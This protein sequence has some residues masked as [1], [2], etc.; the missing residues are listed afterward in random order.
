MAYRFKAYT[1]DKRIVQGTIDAASEG[2][3][4][5]T[6]YQAGYQRVLNLKEIR[7]GLSLGQSIPTLFGIKVQDVID[8]SRQLATLIESG[9]TILTAMQLLEEQAFRAA[10]RKVIAGLIANLRGGSSFSQALSKY[11]QAFSYTYCQVV[12]ASELTGNLEVG[13]RQ[14]AGYM[15]KQA[16][17]R[18]KIT[19]SLAY[20]MM[21]LFMA[22]GVFVLLITVALPPLVGLFTSLGAE[23][24]WTTRLLITAASFLIAHSLLASSR[25][26]V[27]AARRSSDRRIRRHAG[28]L[29]FS[30]K[31]LADVKQVAE[32][33]KHP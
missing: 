16:A 31:V 23:L 7:P 8:F 33:K 21:V 26:P 32:G 2:I 29:G 30:R 24:P 19:R 5:E 6:L 3:A 14:M 28:R 4:E 27:P 22:I 1:V 20:P 17:T 11:P 9:V 18:K 13:L 25:D 10:F 12:R 15:E